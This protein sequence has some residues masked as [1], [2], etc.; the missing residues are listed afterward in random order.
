MDPPDHCQPASTYQLESQPSPLTVL[1]SSHLPAVGTAVSPSPQ[2]SVQTS[3]TPSTEVV[4]SHPVSI[5]QSMS[6]PSPSSSFPSSHISKMSVFVS[7]QVYRNSREKFR[8]R[9]VNMN[10]HKMHLQIHQKLASQKQVC[11][12]A[13]S[14]YYK[15]KLTVSWSIAK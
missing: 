3:A 12:V 7:P 8:I 11:K 10:N 15:S 1:L 5:S 9:R 13:N 4:Q 2:I 14:D 6:H